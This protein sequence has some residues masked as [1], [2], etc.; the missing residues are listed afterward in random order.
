M[1]VDVIM[2]RQNREEKGGSQE[3]FYVGIHEPT[4]L[5]REILESSKMMIHT[6]QSQK[7]V[8]S[9]RE[10]KEK[11]INDFK[12]VVREIN[13]IISKVKKRLPRTKLRALSKEEQLQVY[14]KA[15]PE[16]TKGKKE[17]SKG[18]ET[19]KEVPKAKEEPVLKK[20]E[21]DFDKLQNQLDEIESKLKSI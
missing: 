18:K 9:I 20:K 6:L 21:N 16:V 14:R 17:K 4:D 15:N 12:R 3:S 8:G 2:A 7:K 1:L 5:R 19:A 10:E 11:V 13:L